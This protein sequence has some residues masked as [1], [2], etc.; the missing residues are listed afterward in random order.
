MSCVLMVLRVDAPPLLIHADFLWALGEFLELQLVFSGSYQ[1]V[2]VME[3]LSLG[4]QGSGTQTT[5]SI[6]L[7]ER[8]VQ[9]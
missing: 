4:W 9:G 5:T 2:L 7:H 3:S 1:Y 8:H 6:E